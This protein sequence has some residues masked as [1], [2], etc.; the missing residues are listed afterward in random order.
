MKTIMSE[1]EAGFIRLEVSDVAVNRWLA[2]P[3]S[4]ATEW[5][6]WRKMP[7]AWYGDDGAPVTMQT[8]SDA[9]LAGMLAAAGGGLQQFETTGEALAG[10]MQNVAEPFL[11]VQQYDAGSRTFTAGTLTYSENFTEFLKFLIIARSAAQFLGAGTIPGW[12]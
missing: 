4:N 10:L 5:T 3:V 6:D 8:V 2:S 11:R 1:P 7:G 12:S 9:E